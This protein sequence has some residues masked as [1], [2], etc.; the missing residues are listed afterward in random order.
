[1]KKITTII[2]SFLILITLVSA[3]EL[4]VTQEHPFYLDGEW[5]EAK[6]LQLGDI[7]NTVDGKKVKITSIGEIETEIPF[8]VYN[9]EAGTYH[10]FIVG[11]EKLIVH[12]SNQDVPI[13]LRSPSVSSDEEFFRLVQSKELEIYAINKRGV[14][15]DK[16]DLFNRKRSMLPR[17]Y[18]GW[19]SLDEL[20]NIGRGMR[21]E[22]YSE[23]R[24]LGNIGRVY[25]AATHLDTTGRFIVFDAPAEGTYIWTLSRNGQLNLGLR[26]EL[27]SYVYRS[28]E[29]ILPH[30]VLSGGEP[31]FGA[32]E[33]TFVN[34]E[35]INVN[36]WSGHYVD[37]V[38]S[39][40]FNEN[41]VNSFRLYAE[42]HKLKLHP[43]IEF[44][45][46]S[47]SS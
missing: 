20:N 47:P 19:N 36:A 5:V 39:I 43:N 1:M 37:A 2:L 15:L 40:S 24:E 28:G 14:N 34:G 27:G 16:S 13:K 8:Y 9:L 4:K 41:T 25:D 44:N 17:P 18:D 45:T 21:L 12:N 3:S 23:W 31:V 35:V 38:G 30:S 29:K 10:N 22:T 33:I 26:D 46:G 11:L 7:L 32:G 42:A 6:E